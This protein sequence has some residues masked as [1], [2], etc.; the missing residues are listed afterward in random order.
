MYY[1]YCGLPHKLYSG[2]QV[3]PVGQ[4][5]HGTPSLYGHFSSSRLSL[6]RHAHYR[7]VTCSGNLAHQQLDRT[8]PGA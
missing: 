7:N 6:H 3:V 2:S 8:Y 1:Y 4:V 5:E